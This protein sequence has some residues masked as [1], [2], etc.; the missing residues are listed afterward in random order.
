VLDEEEYSSSRSLVPVQWKTFT[1]LAI[2]TVRSEDLPFKGTSGKTK[3]PGS[4]RKDFSDPTRV[5]SIFIA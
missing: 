1:D 3:V 4:S 5:T 2:T